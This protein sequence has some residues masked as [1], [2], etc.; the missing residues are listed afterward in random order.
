MSKHRD[1]LR[2]KFVHKD[3]IVEEGRIV[4]VFDRETLVVRLQRAHPW[5]TNAL[6]TLA[7]G[8]KS[9]PDTMYLYEPNPNWGTR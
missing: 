8:A 7:P 4:D 2:K 6:V 5:K 3:G 9:I 1:R